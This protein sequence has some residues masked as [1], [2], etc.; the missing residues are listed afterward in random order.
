MPLD[1]VSC[2]QGRLDSLSLNWTRAWSKLNPRINPGQIWPL[3]YFVRCW[4]SSLEQACKVT[5]ASGYCAPIW[6]FGHG[7]CIKNSISKEC[8]CVL[9]RNCEV[10]GTVSWGWHDS[11]D[12]D[13]DYVC[14]VILLD[15]DWPITLQPRSINPAH[16]LLAGSQLGGQLG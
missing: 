10:G 3:A 2:G 14:R 9:D 12:A 16:H 15:R 11:W 5:A 1:H 7:K 8:P 13:L 6:V 4:R